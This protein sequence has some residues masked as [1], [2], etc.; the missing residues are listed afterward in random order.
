[1]LDISLCAKWREFFAANSQMLASDLPGLTG[2]TSTRIMGAAEAFPTHEFT[3]CH[4][5]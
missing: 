2:M 3:H 4:L 1:M 5:L